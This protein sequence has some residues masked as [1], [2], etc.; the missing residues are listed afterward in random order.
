MKGNAVLFVLLIEVVVSSAVIK[1]I[2][3]SNACID[4]ATA[5]CA[6]L[7]C[8]DFLSD[9]SAFEASF[10]RRKRSLM[11]RVINRWTS[12]SRADVADIIAGNF[13]LKSV[14]DRYEKE[15]SV[16]GKIFESFESVFSQQ[17]RQLSGGIVEF[18]RRIESAKI[19]SSIERVVESAEIA[20]GIIDGI[21]NA[22]KAG[23]LFLGQLKKWIFFLAFFAGGILTF[24]IIWKCARK[25]YKNYN[26]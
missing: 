16:L 19:A 3:K 12:R 4:K 7:F 15:A 1:D 20:G 24:K 6:K 9:I 17:S 10:R 26:K 8:E 22:L 23:I 21:G 18:R 14:F 25:I 13:T 5:E 2:D 11:G